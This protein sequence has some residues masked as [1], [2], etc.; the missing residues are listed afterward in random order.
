MVWETIM[1]KWCYKF[2]VYI[3]WEGLDF[4]SLYKFVIFKK[5]YFETLS[6]HNKGRCHWNN[7]WLIDYANILSTATTK[8]DY[9]KKLNPQLIQKINKQFEKYDFLNYQ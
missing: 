9:L 4:I 1:K 8:V 6:K 5:L 7:L 2:P 3:F